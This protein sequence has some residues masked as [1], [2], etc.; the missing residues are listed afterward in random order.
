MEATAMKNNMHHIAEVFR[1]ATEKP[2][3]LIAWAALL[4]QL[5]CM[6]VVYSMG[7]V[8]LATLTGAAAGIVFGAWLHE[9]ARR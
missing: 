2:V 6:L 5:V 9:K 4:I 8:F 3:C 7:P 1:V